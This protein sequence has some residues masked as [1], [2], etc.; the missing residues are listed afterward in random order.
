MEAGMHFFHT[1]IQFLLH[2]LDFVRLLIVHTSTLTSLS[3]FL[4]SLKSSILIHMHNQPEKKILQ[5]LH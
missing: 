4:V 1:K 2:S 3:D 5:V